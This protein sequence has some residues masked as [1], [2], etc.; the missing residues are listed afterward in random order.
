MDDGVERLVAV[1][2]RIAEAIEDGHHAAALIAATIVMQKPDKPL[3]DA[4]VSES[5]EALKNMFFADI[6]GEP[7][8]APDPKLITKKP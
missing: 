4:S 8:L 7:L 5:I 3:S 1:L 6:R 2:E